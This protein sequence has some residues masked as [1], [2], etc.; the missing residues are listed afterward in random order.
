M[1]LSYPVDEKETV[2]G[3]GGSGASIRAGPV[4]AGLRTVVILLFLAPAFLIGGC[5]SEPLPPLT[6]FEQA[7]YRDEPRKGSL[8]IYRSTAE[9]S[10]HK[11]IPANI[12]IDKQPFV[13]LKGAEYVQVYLSE[14]THEI[15]VE[16]YRPCENINTKKWVKTILLEPEHIRYL[17]IVPG[18]GG[19]SWVWC[20]P[21]Q[22]VPFP[23]IGS[24]VELFMRDAE[25]ARKNMGKEI[26]EDLMNTRRIP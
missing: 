8:V 22:L 5:A 7:L 18:F 20:S 1:S 2:E 9:S 21:M 6:E 10:I 15:V 14:G 25:D 4:E 26:T 16:F 23:F 11:P 17:E 24:K 19:M 12:F 3:F 13:F